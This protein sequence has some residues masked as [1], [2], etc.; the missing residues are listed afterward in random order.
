MQISPL[1]LFKN[2]TTTLPSNVLFDL[3]PQ[4]SEV[5]SRAD[6]PLEE[7]LENF[8]SSLAP[9]K[10]SKITKYQDYIYFKR[11]EKFRS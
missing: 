6:V 4:Y 3:F 2:Q 8:D 7:T 1:F 11:L 5:R 9:I 10:V